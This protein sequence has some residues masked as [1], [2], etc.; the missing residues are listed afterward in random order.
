M[1]VRKKPDRSSNIVDDQV[2]S[3]EA[4]FFFFSLEVTGWHLEL[5][6]DYIKF[7]MC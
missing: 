6:K 2:F 4:T 3:I 1:C 5:V 7:D